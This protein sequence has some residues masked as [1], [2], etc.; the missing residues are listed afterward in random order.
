M[1]VCVCVCISCCCCYCSHLQCLNFS[2]CLTFLAQ[3]PSKNYLNCSGEQFVFNAMQCNAIVNWCWAKVFNCKTSNK[4]RA[5]IVH[6]TLA[7]SAI[8]TT[9]C[10][11]SFISDSSDNFYQFPS[12]GLPH[13][14]SDGQ[15]AR[16]QWGSVQD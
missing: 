14:S 13:W 11:M 1:F 7:N 6:A 16:G 8:W 2:L 4:N 5:A 15:L 10:Q 12:C 9:M 3:N